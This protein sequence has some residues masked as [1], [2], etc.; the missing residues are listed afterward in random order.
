MMLQAPAPPGWGSL[1]LLP[2]GE[3][4]VTPRADESDPLCVG[5][6]P[7]GLGGVG[8]GLFVFPQLQMTVGV[9]L[10]QSRGDAGRLLRDEVQLWETRTYGRTS[11]PKVRRAVWLKPKAPGRNNEGTEHKEAQSGAQTCERPGN[12]GP[13]LLPGDSP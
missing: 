13:G 3:H 11:V 6:C 1:S 2:P 12:R 8:S 9:F 10:G 4:P 7:A 5:T